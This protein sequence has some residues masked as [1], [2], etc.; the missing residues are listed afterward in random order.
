MNR[1]FFAPSNAR[2]LRFLVRRVLAAVAAEL[3]QLQTVFDRLF[4]LARKIVDA[5]ALF[6][7]HFDQVVLGHDRCALIPLL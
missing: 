2:L 3:G 5:P 6:A 7:L 1:V 4:V